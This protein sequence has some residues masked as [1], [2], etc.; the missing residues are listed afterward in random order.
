MIRAVALLAVACGA[1]Q[2]ETWLYR[3]DLDPAEPLIAK[4]LVELPATRR[5]QDFSVQVR[6]LAGG[7]MPQVADIRCDGAPLAPDSASAWRVQGWGCVRLTWT[8]TMAAPPDDGVDLRDRQSFHDP[9]ARYWLFS[10]ASS[11]LRPVGAARHEGEVEF[12]GGGPVQGSEQSGSAS[13]RL[14]PA[15]DQPAE[16]YVIGRLPGATVREGGFETLHLDADGEDWRGL[17]AAQGR[18]LEYL[19]RAAGARQLAPLRSTVVWLHGATDEGLP[20]GVAGRRTL[21]LSTESRG[22]HMQH[23]EMALAWMLREQLLQAMPERVP[24]W[25]RE[26]L[27]QY[28]AIKAL[29]RS[30]LP[31]AAIA[32]VEKRLIDAQ[33]PRGGLREAQRRLEAGDPA[34][35]AELH[36]AGAAFWERLD[37]AIARKAGFRTLDSALPRLLA[38]EWPGGRLPPAVLERLRNYAGD[39]AVDDLLTLYVGD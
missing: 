19:V 35:R 33:P 37:R 20:V 38:A 4:V 27:A 7:V 21:L 16:F 29:R 2:A 25:A 30:G 3:V 6:G 14:V 9:R 26:S 15:A 5:A 10:E 23:A 34:A 12:G 13:G 28:Y 18:A 32:A 31:P 39:A 24:R 1:A 36:A 22:G 8:V 11:L 17:L